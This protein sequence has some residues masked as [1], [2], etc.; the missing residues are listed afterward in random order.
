MLIFT[1]CIFCF[2]LPFLPL[3]ILELPFQ[4]PRQPL[5]LAERSLT[6]NFW[7]YFRG[8]ESGG[9]IYGTHLQCIDLTG[10]ALNDS[11][12]DLDVAFKQMTSH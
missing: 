9:L 4:F 6:E 8:C 5:L 11:I 7:C 10:T 1:V 2:L 12:H 3:V